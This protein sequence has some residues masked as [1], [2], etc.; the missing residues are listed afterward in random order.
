MAARAHAADRQLRHCESVSSGLGARQFDADLAAR[1]AA[2]RPGSPSRRR[3]APD[4][5]RSTGQGPIRARDSSSRAPRLQHLLRAAR[6]AGPDRCPRPPAPAARRVPGAATARTRSSPYLQ[7][8]SSTLP[9]I[10]IRSCRS[11]WKTRSS[12]ARQ[13]ISMPRS[14]KIRSSVWASSSSTGAT[15]VRSRRPW[16]RA[17]ARARRRWWSTC[18]R[19]ASAWRVTTSASG[20]GLALGLGQHHRQ[21]RLQ[22]MG[23]I[24]DVG[25]LALHHLLVV[26]H[27]GVELLGQGLELGRDSRRPAARPC[28]CAPRPPRAAGRTAA[29][30]P[31]RTWMNTASTRPEAQDH[32]GAGGHRREAAR[33][34]VDRACGPPPP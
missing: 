32:Q 13:S 33:G 22:R 4:R 7:A 24:A 19:M 31:T 14:R 2:N 34:R 3:P 10:S 30:R 6:R 5:R 29:A 12:S 26:G 15:G 21:R 18:S 25:A 17:A 28:R 9:T 27:Q 20:A 1:P 11:P 16:E 23:Q 8:F